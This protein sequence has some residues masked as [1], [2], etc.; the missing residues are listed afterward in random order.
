MYARMQSAIPGRRCL[1]RVAGAAGALFAIYQSATISVPGE[2]TGAV[3]Y[4][5]ELPVHVIGSCF[6]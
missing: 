5:F 1:A 4:I 6:D 2:H 3:E